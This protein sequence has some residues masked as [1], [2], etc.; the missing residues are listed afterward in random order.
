MDVPPQA[1]VLCVRTARTSL[2][3]ARA[4]PVRRRRRG[5]VVLARLD[6]APP[7]ERNLLTG[8]RRRHAISLCGAVVEHQVRLRAIDMSV[9]DAWQP[10]SS[11]RKGAVFGVL[12]DPS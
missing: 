6:P 9:R 7:V 10:L 11:Q 3:F 1:T 12:W 2:L 4:K 5:E 8:D